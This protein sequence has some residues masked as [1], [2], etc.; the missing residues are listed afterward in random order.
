MIGKRLR[1]RR[2]ELGMTQEE[3][4]HKLGYKSKSTIN[5]IELDHHDVSQ[6]KLIKLAEALECSPTYF[7]ED[8]EPSVDISN[9]DLTDAI[10]LYE[11][12]K[13]AIPQVQ[14]AV[15]LLLK[16]SQSEP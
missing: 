14:E 11:Y 5:K 9:K 7:I 15:D 2:I 12:Y 1:S 8:D 3:L 4:A 16:Q 6:S 10:R 13:K